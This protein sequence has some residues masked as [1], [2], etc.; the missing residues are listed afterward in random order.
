MPR[1]AQRDL[2]TGI[3]PKL[4]KNGTQSMPVTT[5]DGTPGIHKADIFE[6]DT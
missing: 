1:S 4:R 6:T 2:P 3:T 5:A